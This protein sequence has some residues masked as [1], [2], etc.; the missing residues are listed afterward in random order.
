MTGT[1]RYR[2]P[3]KVNDEEEKEREGLEFKSPLPLSSPAWQ[4][5]S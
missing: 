5:M 4:K 3:I 1:K 2:R